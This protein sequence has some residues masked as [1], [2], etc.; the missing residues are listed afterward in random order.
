VE[1]VP[2][3]H[4]NSR[5]AGVEPNRRAFIAKFAG[6]VFAAPVISS[7]ALDGIAQARPATGHRHDCRHHH[8][9]YGNMSHGNQSYG[10]Q[11]YGNMSHGNQC[12]GNMSHGNQC[13]GN[14]SYGNM[15]Y[16]NGGD[17]DE[18]H[19]DPYWWLF[20][21]CFPFDNHRHRRPSWF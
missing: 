17:R 8:H 20:G 19:D 1:L 5:L 2:N 14:M 9:H 10:N 21:E 11:C 16:G 12:Y 15:S 6:A 18:C 13:Y 3:S 7:F 4:R